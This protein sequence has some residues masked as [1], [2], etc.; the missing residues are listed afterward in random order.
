MPR[1]SDHDS[2]SLLQKTAALRDTGRRRSAQPLLALLLCLVSAG[3]LLLAPATAQAG[4]PQDQAGAPASSPAPPDHPEQGAAPATP[5]SPSPASP[6]AASPAPAPAPAAS[7]PHAT[8]PPKLTKKQQKEAIAKLP[9]KYRDWL[10]A[11]EVLITPVEKS[12]FLVLDK[13]Y[14][15]DAFIQHF[16][17]AREAASGQRGEFQ[18]N[19]EARVAEARERFGKELV[20]ERA[21]VFLL[22]GPPAAEVA[23][24]CSTILWP[25]DVWYYPGS[26]RTNEEFII[27]FYQHWGAGPYRVWDPSS[28]LGELLAD[29][30]REERSLNAIAN[31]CRDGDKV[32]GAIAW[33]S[34][35]GMHYASLQAAFESKPKAPHTEWVNSFRSYS[36]DLPAGVELLPAKLAVSF[37]GHAG[38]RTALQGTVTLPAAAAGQVKLADRRSYDLLLTGEV[39][40]GSHLFE[41]FRYKFDFPLAAAETNL[42]LVFQRLLRPGEYTLVVKLE[43]LNS[44]RMF[45]AAQKVVVPQVDEALPPP[46]PSDPESARIFKEANDAMLNGANAVKI[47]APRGEL[48][49][50]MLRF[51]TLVS[52][53]IDK[54]T[55]ALDHKPL[56]TKRKPP[57]SVELDL[58]SLPRPHHLTATAYDAAG[59]E[60]ANDDLLVNSAGQ[61][62]RVHLVEPQRGKRYEKSLLVR[63]DTEVPDGELI[64]HV[65]IYLDE[66]LVATL[67]QPPYTQPVALAKNQAL[68][69][70]R[71][72][73]YTADGNSTE[74]LVFIN[75]PGEI[76]Q[77]NVQ[78]VELYT[79]VLDRGLRPVAGLAQKDFTVLEDGHRQEVTR[80]ERVTDLPIH[81]AVVLDTSASMEK[82]L[83]TSRD[84]ALQFL[85]Q[86]IRPKDRAAI[87]TFNDHPNIVVKFANDLTTLAGGL[88]GLKA[89]R[90]TALWD[91]IIFTLYYFNGVK[92]QRAAL[93]LSDGRDEGSRFSFEEALEYT[94]RSGVTLFTIGLG[95]DVDKRKLTKISEE[96][97]GRAFYVKSAAELPA[98][99][100]TIQE[101]LRSQYLIAYQSTNTSLDGNFRTVEVKVDRSGLEVKTLHGYYP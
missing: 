30:N 54:V 24:H 39:L 60:V 90:G 80:F 92:G 43:D 35:Q 87:I 84:A 36:T 59:Q 3:A 57:Y 77:L 64:D 18:H 81:A 94:R 12:A 89:E 34:A 2:V 99:Y 44:P 98:I 23:T 53:Q 41:N 48:Q 75:A 29:T 82:A 4:A 85:Q 86:A 71:A 19:F 95:D 15:R 7:S 22:N 6:P 56:L 67:Y 97:G 40:Q 72:V 26:D 100:K 11:V 58:G 20:D 8:A 31:G 5:P 68:S 27:V 61:R 101:E 96:T 45:R 65:E 73:A 93:L 32:A 47:I 69:Y 28:G 66:A 25:V 16:W 13:D 46:P 88:A 51:D 42:P 91:T 49:T 1:T 33:V 52:G 14:Q 63:A 10:V 50:G 74:D 79:S 37:P 78:Y 55:F 62:F 70:V 9:E 83:D 76:E 17:E 21:R 38:N